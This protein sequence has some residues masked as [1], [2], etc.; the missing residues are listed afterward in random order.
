MDGKTWRR[1][2]RT[3]QRGELR[4]NVIYPNLRK[5][6]AQ[7]AL[8]DLKRDKLPGLAVHPS[9]SS[10]RTVKPF[11]VRQG[12]PERS[13]RAHHKRLNLRLPLLKLAA[14][15][16]MWWAEKCCLPQDTFVDFFI[17]SITP[18]RRDA[19]ENCDVH[20][21]LADEFLLE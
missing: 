4:V 18:P 12:S 15:L 7:H 2:C 16:S 11:M 8:P 14:D 6:R 1:A 3:R 21:S 5:R 20:A 9:T 10:G 17:G 13:R 19:I